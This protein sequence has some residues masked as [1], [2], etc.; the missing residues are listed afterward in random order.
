ML[1]KSAIEGVLNDKVINGLACIF[2]ETGFKYQ[3]SKKQFV[4][5]LDCF[6][7]SI[8]IETPYSPVRYDP[9]R[10]RWYLLVEIYSSITCP[11]YEKWKLGKTFKSN[12]LYFL[13]HKVNVFLDL[14]LD[15]FDGD[16]FYEPNNHQQFRSALSIAI[17][18]GQNPQMDLLPFDTFK[19]IEISKIVESLN[20][21]SDLQ[22]I[23]KLKNI[24]LEH[25][26]FFAFLGRHDLASEHYSMYQVSLFEKIDLALKVSNTEAKKHLQE[27]ES[28][29]KCA[30][31]ASNIQLKNP[32][33]QTIKIL[34]SE[35]DRID[36][37]LNTRFVEKVRL[38]ISQFNAEQVCINDFGEILLVLNNRRVVKLSRT[39]EMVFEFEIEPKKGFNVWDSP[40]VGVVGTDSF[41]V[42]N[43]IVSR[44]NEILELPIPKRNEKK[45]Q[46]SDVSCLQFWESKNVFVVLYENFLLTYNI[47]GEL[48]NTLDIGQKYGRQIFLDKEWLVK[49]VDDSNISIENFKGELINRFHHAKDNDKFEFSSDYEYL[50]CYYFATKSQIFHLSS[51]KQS[52]L[53][54]HPTFIKGY[55]ES[56]YSDT[57]NNFGIGIAK[58]SPDVE[59]IV[60][61][62]YNGK[63]VAWKLPTYDR[64][65]LIPNQAA[66]ESLEH[67]R[68]SRHSDGHRIEEISQPNVVVIENQKFLYNRRNEIT[69]ILFFENGDV[70]ATE[71]SHGKMVLSW[72]RTFNNI[73][74]KQLQGKLGYHANRFITQQSKSQVVVY[75]QE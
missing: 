68:T 9:E 23:C 66:I 29:V 44:S 35:N 3:K 52:T 7:Q 24:P 62:A 26:Y 27:L 10:N 59:Y 43:Y 15:D 45:I 46:N 39:G 4:R 30:K 64:V 53:W 47:S 67:F 6:E 51:S 57:E 16:S 12:T 72:D 60:A 69:Q 25:G 13:S 42:N 50:I 37:S 40:S 70:F 28:L 1:K 11:S 21:N 34:P 17:S 38:D 75:E 73:Y 33:E 74:H 5:L 65:E 36:F 55:K 71:I 56:L 19:D 18:Q 20:L 31:L 49:R 48:E 2:D 32:Y 54:A 22:E 8:R 14:S 61:G 41:H 58:F 63:Y